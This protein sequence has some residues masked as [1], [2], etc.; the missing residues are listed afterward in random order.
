MLK[1]RLSYIG[2]LMMAVKHQIVVYLI[3]Y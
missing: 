3:G 1:I 2:Q